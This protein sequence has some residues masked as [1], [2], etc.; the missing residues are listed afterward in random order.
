MKN[1]WIAAASFALPQAG[2]AAEPSPP[3]VPAAVGALAGCWEGEGEVM[4]K[5]VTIMVAARPIAEGALLTLDAHSRA[6]AD[7][8]DRYAAHLVFGGTGKPNDAQAGAISGYWSD[9]FGGAY[10]ATGQGEATTDGFTITY[11]Y[12]DAAFRNRWR[13]AGDQLTWQI[14]AVSAGGAEKLFARYALRKTACPTTP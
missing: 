8:A 10:T 2:L 14:V 7:A 4:E 3:R 9:S 11:P 5:P 1:A 13:F 6:L 12:P